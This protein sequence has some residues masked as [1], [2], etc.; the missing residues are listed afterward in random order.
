MRLVARLSTVALGLLL[1]AAPPLSAADMGS[2]GEKV[3][4]GAQ[5]TGEKIKEG[6]EKAKEKVSD[7]FHKAEDKVTTKNKSDRT[8]RDPV[9][10]AQESLRDKGYDPGP[11][12]GKMGPK[13]RQAVRE[14]QTKEGLKPTG[15]LDSTTMA[16]LGAGEHEAS[17]SASPATERAPR[18]R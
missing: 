13:T 3:K 2:A 8:D 4:E 6:A 12:D 11:A 16:R 10:A 15:T 17:P 5:T 14:F 7:T 1:L 9:K 18:T